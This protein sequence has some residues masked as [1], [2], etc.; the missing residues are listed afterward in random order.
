VS[1]RR[2][3]SHRQARQFQRRGVPRTPVI[4]EQDLPSGQEV[5]E[6]ALEGRADNPATIAAALSVLGGLVEQTAEA[7]VAVQETYGSGNAVLDAWDALDDEE[8]LLAM[9]AAILVLAE[10]IRLLADSLG[11]DTTDWYS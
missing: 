1:R 3:P 5:W 10:R 4:E 6:L 9:R 2:R 7:I 11:L 8:D